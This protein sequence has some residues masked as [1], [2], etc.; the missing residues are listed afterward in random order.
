MEDGRDAIERVHGVVN[1]D[2]V[3]RHVAGV[4][5]FIAA[6]GEVDVDLVADLFARH[7]VDGE[8]GDVADET[9][10]RWGQREC[11]SNLAVETP[12][13]IGITLIS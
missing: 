7:E 5:G 9:Q 12:D 2:L 3:G 11:V 13:H 6:L 1:P 4:R 8:A 10:A